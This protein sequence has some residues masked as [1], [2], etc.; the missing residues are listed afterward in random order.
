MR[1]HMFI[2]VFLWSSFLR[3]T[4]YRQV[5]IVFVEDP[6]AE[7]YEIEWLEKDPRQAKTSSHIEKIYRS[8]VVRKVKANYLYFRM[9]SV[10]GKNYSPWTEPYS[11]ASLTEKITYERETQTKDTGK[12]DQPSQELTAKEGDVMSTPKPE[13]PTAQD[14]QHK[15]FVQNEPKAVNIENFP[16]EKPNFKD[17]VKSQTPQEEIKEIESHVVSQNPVNLEQLANERPPYYSINES[18]IKPY[19]KPIDIT[20]DGSYNI[21]LYRNQLAESQYRNLRVI[22]DTTPPQTTVGFYQPVIFDGSQLWISYHSPIEL[23]AED[24]L[25]GV[26]KIWFRLF[27]SSMP[28]GDFEEYRGNFTLEQKKL[29]ADELVYIEFYAEDLAQNK[30]KL[31]RIV[32]HADL[33]APKIEKVHQNGPRYE[34]WFQEKN[35]PVR[36]VLWKSSGQK[37]KEGETK[38]LLLL[39]NAE[40]G[41]YLIE[42]K[43]NF[44]NSAQE[45]FTLP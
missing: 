11:L 9:R 4:L 24:N 3:A 42:L 38:K 30:E 26:R 1:Y 2:I 45:K 32:L 17:A 13:Q 14:T 5:T 28:P 33:S 18:E 29:S 43:D 41:N 27:A 36:Y 19:E 40:P 34:I 20:S 8:P 21:A 7:Y 16:K 37:I 31:N 15:D 25:S 12:E 44:G 39:E 10:A 23:R 35:P 22:M 6:R